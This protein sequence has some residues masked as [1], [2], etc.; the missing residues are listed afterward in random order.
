MYNMADENRNDSATSDWT[1]LLQS[2]NVTQNKT[3]EEDNSH[4]GND[5]LLKPE[6]IVAIIL[7]IVGLL[8]NLL[9]IVAISKVRGRLTSNLR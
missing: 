1:L 2:L 8:A 6:R 4:Q 7:S 9:S 5:T 3:G